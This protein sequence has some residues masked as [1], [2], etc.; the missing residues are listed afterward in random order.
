MRPEIPSPN[1]QYN[2]FPI[3]DLR[4]RIGAAA[5]DFAIALVVSSIVTSVLG[6]GALGSWLLFLI[7]W[8]VIRVLFVLNNQGQ[9]PGHWALDMKVVN[10][11][12]GRLPRQ[13]WMLRREGAIGFVCSL[14]LISLQNQSYGILI[15][16]LAIP[17][18]FDGW[19]ASTDRQLGQTLHDRWGKTVVINT[20]RGY[21]LDLKIQQW[22]ADFQERSRQSRG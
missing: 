15:F 22:I 16:V 8:Y 17:V 9:S 6:G 11:N 10:Q 20:L 19:C 18:G 4:R 2:Q 12:S 21:S 7:C 13:E 1:Q 3:A 14:L 5:I